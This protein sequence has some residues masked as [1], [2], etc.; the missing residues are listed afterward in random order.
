[1]LQGTGP[2]SM[3]NA[4]FIYDTLWSNSQGVAQSHASVQQHQDLS[5][6][7]PPRLMNSCRQSG[8]AL[9]LVQDQ[10]D[11]ILGSFRF[12]KTELLVVESH[13]CVVPSCEEM[14]GIPQPLDCCSWC[15]SN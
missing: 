6:R 13:G 5:L 7:T 10:D 1:M 15:M 3:A 14:A 4:Q 2:R 11:A 9:P 8:I 12:R